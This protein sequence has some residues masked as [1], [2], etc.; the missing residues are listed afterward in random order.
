MLAVFL[1]WAA[2]RFSLGNGRVFALYAMGYAFGRFWVEELR[3]DTANHIFGLRVNTW[4]MMI[5]FIGGAIW[6]A[7]H[8]GPA[9]PSIFRD[10]SDRHPDRSPDSTI[11]PND[12]D[13]SAPPDDMDTAAPVDAHVDPPHDVD[14]PATPV[15]TPPEEM[16]PA[17]AAEQ[18][19][20]PQS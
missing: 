10:D 3:S 2:R 13:A 14:D 5:V 6:F 4:T 20:T 15:E 12:A 8:R 9:E 16:Q 17:L 18:S 7:T 11:T 19:D 1:I